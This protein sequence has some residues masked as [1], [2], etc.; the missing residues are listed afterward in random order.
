MWEQPAT[1]P[2][3]TPPPFPA[4]QQFVAPAPPTKRSRLTLTKRKTTGILQSATG[5]SIIFLIG[6]I[7]F[8]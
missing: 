4:Q 5:I 1:T 3:S 7:R 2:P 6:R 8:F